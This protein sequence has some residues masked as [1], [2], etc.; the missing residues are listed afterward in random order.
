MADPPKSA[1]PRAE[2]PA[3]AEEP[4]PSLLD[5]VYAA[6]R[7]PRRL[8]FTREG[9]YYFFFTL[10]VGIAALNTGNNLLFLVLGLQLTAI[11]VSGILSEIALQKL[12]VVRELPRDPA[13]REPFPLRYRITNR[14]RFW[15]SL[16]ILIGEKGGPFN[17]AVAPLL[18]VGPGETATAST[19]CEVPWRGRFELQEITLSTRF[20]FGLF[21]KSR[22]LPL[23]GTLWILP[24]RI[25]AAERRIHG[26]ARDGERPEGRAGHGAEFL[27]LRELKPGDD[28]RQVHWLKSASAGRLLAI[29]R[30]REQRRRVVIVL[31]NRG[32]PDDPEWLD[33]PV[34][35]AAALLRLLSLRGM[36]VGLSVSG[37]YA[38]PEHGAE[39]V[40]RRLRELAEL[41]VAPASGPAPETRNEGTIEVERAPRQRSAA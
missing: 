20:P 1:T 11:I 5:R 25:K 37:R 38:A 40:R 2:R 13:A 23:P 16:T 39:A 17:G 29:E 30:E 34:E 35:E 8:K 32:D 31:D 22:D 27:G 9:W 33:A 21:E 26:G 3:G 10:G 19:R 18:A 7:P 15:P 28:R 4:R 41:G 36:E 6:L 24:A 12:E 14:K